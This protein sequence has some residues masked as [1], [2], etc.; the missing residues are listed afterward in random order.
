MMNS[1][2]VL[3]FLSAFAAAR[4]F[5]VSASFSTRNAVTSKVAS[6]TTVGVPNHGHLSVTPSPSDIKNSFDAVEGPAV[7]IT[8]TT[9]MH[10]PCACPSRIASK[11]SSAPVSKP[12]PTRTGKMAREALPVIPTQPIVS[13]PPLTRTVITSRQSSMSPSSPS[14]PPLTCTVITSRQSSASPTSNSGPPLTR[15]VI[16]SKQSSTSPS[17]PPLTRTVITSRLLPTMEAAPAV[18]AVS[19]HTTA[20]T[21]ADTPTQTTTSLQPAATEASEKAKKRE[22]RN[23]ILWTVLPI[24]LV[25]PVAWFLWAVAIPLLVLF[26]VWVER[27]WV[28]LK[29]KMRGGSQE[30][31]QDVEAARGT[32]RA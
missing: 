8:V 17:G 19:Y 4:P 29:A 20:L 9:T 11:L 7:T 31:R 24:V 15:T 2:T 23:Q 27:R 6:P 30:T 10:H 12:T 18:K 21:N 28:A 1:A 13:G 3:L 22:K 25:I 32:S 26:W 16:T 14:G 5:E